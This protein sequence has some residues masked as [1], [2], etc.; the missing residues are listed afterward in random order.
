M[1]LSSHHDCSATVTQPLKAFIPPSLRLRAETQRPKR[2]LLVNTVQ[3]T[4]CPQCELHPMFDSL[5]G[6]A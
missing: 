3:V 5:D 1:S 6:P 2:Q 4:V